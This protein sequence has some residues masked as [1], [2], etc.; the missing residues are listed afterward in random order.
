MSEANVGKVFSLTGAQGVPGPPGK[1]G[2]DGAALTFDQLTEEQKAQLKGP[3]GDTGAAL[4]FDQ[5]TE[6]QKAQLK[7]PKGDTGAALTF[8]Q[9]TEEQKAQ[10]KGERGEPGAT[11][12]TGAT[13]PAGPK[14]DT[15]STGA[16][17]PAGPKGDPGEPPTSMDASAITGILSLARGGTGQS[18]AAKALYALING[19]TTLTSTTIATGD[20]IPVSDVSAATGKRITLANLAA[21]LGGGIVVGT[22]TGTGSGPNVTQSEPEALQII[23]LGFR[24]KF[25]VV[26]QI[27]SFS[28]SAV[29]WFYDRDEDGVRTAE[30]IVV[31]AVDG[32]PITYRQG[33]YDSGYTECTILETTSTGFQVRCANYRRKSTTYTRYS[34]Y[35]PNLE[36]LCFY[37]AVK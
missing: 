34:S 14:G 29:P 5:L 23:S 13:G 8:D 21:A 16:T 11:G 1:D 9:L 31:F 3:K 6:E 22:F 2:K 24:P 19:A 28:G 20:Y 15:G 36:G 10:L 26:G 27:E 35:L 33:D 4:T 7:G 30:S 25:I 18:T 12:A 17:G 37:I 32:R